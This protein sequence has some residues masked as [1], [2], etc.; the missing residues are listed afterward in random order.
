MKELKSLNAALLLQFFRYGEAALTGH[1]DEINALNVYPV[2]DG[3]TGTN[4]GLTIKSA[5][6]NLDDTMSVKELCAVISR[7]ALMGARGNSGVILSQILRGFTMS[8]Q[9]QPV[10]DGVA[11]ANALQKGVEI[12]Y[13]SV[14]KPVEGTILTVGRKAAEAAV[15]AA[16]EEPNIIAVLNSALS[17]GKI[18]LD[19]TP[20]QLAVLKEAGV[21][22]AGGKGLLYLFE[23][24]LAALNGEEMFVIGAKDDLVV[25]DKTAA[26][27]AEIQESEIKYR[28]CTEL[29]I[30]NAKK[31]H[32]YAKKHITKAVDGDSLVC[33]GDEGIIKIHY[34]SNDPGKIISFALTI[35]ELFDIKV[36]NMKEQMAREAAEKRALSQ[37]EAPPLA[38]EP[39]K[40]RKKCAVIAVSSGEGLTEIFKGLGADE[41]IFGGQTM[42]PSAEDMINSMA[43][44]NAEEFVILPN[45]SNIIL[46]AQ[47]V[48]EICDFPVEIVPS[49]FMTQG[50]AA[51][52]MFS[53]DQSAAENK[54][55][56]SEV[57][58]GVQNGEITFS[59]R[60]TVTDGI[61]IKAGDIL[62]LLNGKIIA[63]EKSV[64]DGV[65]ALLARMPIDDSSLLTLYYGHDVTAAAASALKETLAK[66]YPELEVEL[67][68]G[69]QPLYHYLISLE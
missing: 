47:Q 58:P 33:V 46:G 4:M 55:A 5:V 56:M 41:V 17:A 12:A 29:M 1:K 10:I 34:H 50:L 30:H 61:E 2:P 53:G 19:N 49:K 23:G 68:E 43:K 8:L 38:T 7:G 59:I 18:A 64:E 60:D 65:F 26:F 57:L 21:V 51:M 22:D 31:D 24:G 15:A 35:G 52:M 36:E 28:Y 44:V 25:K 32:E 54:E 69:T 48:A 14:L 9:N 11:F 37:K 39:P 40:P 6:K 45:N 62:V 63:A 27:A 16:K 67:Y 13:K 20:N 66:R 3:D 42:N